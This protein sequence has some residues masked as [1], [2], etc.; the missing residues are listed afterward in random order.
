MLLDTIHFIL[1]FISIPIDYTA[2]YL[3]IL[4]YYF[5]FF[6]VIVRALQYIYKNFI[7]NKNIWKGGPDS[8]AVVTGGTDGIGL[9]FC[10]QLEDKVYNIFVLSRTQSKLEKVKR[11]IESSYKVQCK[12]L[13]EDFTKTDIYGELEREIQKLTGELVKDTIVQC[14]PANEQ[15]QSTENKPSSDEKSSLDRKSV[16]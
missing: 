12:T 13:P 11:E 2:Y 3:G 14:A 6:V 15:D 5:F 4:L 9:E 16:V 7:I 10:R 8:W 1:H